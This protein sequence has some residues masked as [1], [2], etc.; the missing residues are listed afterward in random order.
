MKRSAKSPDFAAILRE[1]PAT[2]LHGNNHKNHP[3]VGHV[4]FFF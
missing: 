4:G 3:V 2:T 1:Q